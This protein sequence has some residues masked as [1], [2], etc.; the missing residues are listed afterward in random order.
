MRIMRNG[1]K[2]HFISQ[3]AKYLRSPRL[4]ELFTVSTAFPGDCELR[5]EAY[6]GHVW[7]IRKQLGMSWRA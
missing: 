1:T 5:K 6:I 2:I 4:L 3:N 7:L